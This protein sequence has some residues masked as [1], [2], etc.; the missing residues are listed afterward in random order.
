MAR[1]LPIPVRTASDYSEEAVEYYRNARE[2]LDSVRVRDERYVYVKRV[3]EACGTAYLA[4]LAAI[5]SFLMARGVPHGKL[6]QEYKAYGQALSR[7]GARNGKVLQS[8]HRAYGILHLD[9]YYQG[10]RSTAT[11][12]MGFAYAKFVIERLTGRRVGG[13]GGS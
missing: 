11:G 10:F 1:R 8:F 3:R 2:L 12:E 9:G 5:K 7:H 6:P 4:V 13:D